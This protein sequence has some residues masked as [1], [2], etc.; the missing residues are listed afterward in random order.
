MKQPIFISITI[1]GNSCILMG[2]LVLYIAEHDINP[3]LHTVL[4]AIWWAVATVS[5]VGYGDISPVT[6]LGKIVGIGM[7]I[8]GTA[9][10]STYTA[11]FAGALVVSE[12]E[13]IE[14][15]LGALK[16]RDR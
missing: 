11:L 2:T 7:M 4:D 3:K 10:F 9:L 8:I 13:D 14:R 15:E 12:I 1:L 16:K 6:P 5:T